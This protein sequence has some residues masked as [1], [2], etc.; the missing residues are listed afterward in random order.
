M[1][2]PPGPPLRIVEAGTFRGRRA[3]VPAASRVPH[4]RRFRDV[5]ASAAGRWTRPVLHPAQPFP[6]AHEEQGCSCSAFAGLANPAGGGNSASRPM[7]WDEFIARGGEALPVILGTGLTGAA[8]SRALS[9]AGVVHALVGEPPDEG[10]AAGRVPERGGQPGSAP[11]VPRS[12]AVF[13]EKRGQVLLFG[14]HAVAFDALQLG[15]GRV[16]HRWLG[17]PANVRLL[18]VDRRGLDRALFDTAVADVHCVSIAERVTDLEYR[19]VGDR[20]EAVR[21]AD[22]RRLAASYLFDATNHLRVA[23][24]RIG[25]GVPKA[26]HGAAGGVRPR[27]RSGPAGIPRPGISFRDRRRGETGRAGVGRPPCCASTPEPIGW[28]GWPGASR[29]GTTFP[30]GSASIRRRCEPG[31]RRFWTGWSV[32]TRPG[33]STFGRISRVARR[34]WI[35]CTTITTTSAAMGGTGC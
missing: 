1:R 2:P 35:S 29:W 26:G 34:R 33:G 32:R 17:L 23:A 16:F 22:G 14:E 25:G 5:T 28:M 18:H 7:R 8:I 12:G 10:T 9:A 4:S 21:F 24:R 3:A 19:A 20:V 27:V 30:S 11:P 15:A 6:R 13:H 31:R